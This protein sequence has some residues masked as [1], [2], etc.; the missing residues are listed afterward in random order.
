MAIN[1]DTKPSS[2]KPVEMVELFTLNGHAYEIPNK[3]RM[4]VALRFLD[5]AR[6]NGQDQAAAYLIEVLLGREAYEA[7]MNYDDLSPEDFQSI[8]QAA[9]KV[10]L[11]DLE[12]PKEQK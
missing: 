2:D 12:A 9:V 4:N 10:V 5:E 7:L 6:R 8:V 11:G 1:F 3:A